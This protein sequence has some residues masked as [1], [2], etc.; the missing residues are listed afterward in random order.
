ML[1]SGAKAGCC[2]ALYALYNESSLWRFGWAS[3]QAFAVRT[4]ERFSLFVAAIGAAAYPK[5]LERVQEKWKPVFR[6]D[7]RQFKELERDGDSTKTHPAPNREEESS[8]T[9]DRTNRSEEASV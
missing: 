8:R 1:F 3:K 7:T 4:V 5:A 9:Y 2:A 6:P